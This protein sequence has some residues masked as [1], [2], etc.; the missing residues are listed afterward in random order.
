MPNPTYD[1]Q[2]PDQKELIE[3]VEH[4]IAKATAS[5]QTIGIT[6]ATAYRELVESVR[7]VARKAPSEYLYPLAIDDASGGVTTDAIHTEVTCP[8]NF[9]R[10]L[11][12][13]LGDWKREVTDL[14]PFG[15]D[16]WRLQ[17]NKF[18]QADIYNP[19]A[20]LKPKGADAQV[21]QCFPPDSTDTV[22]EFVFVTDDQAPES[23]PDEL[24]D[25]ISYLAASRMLAN[26]RQYDAAQAL[27]A[28]A[29]ELLGG[30]RFGFLGE[31]LATE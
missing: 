30:V 17:W 27:K 31:D 26:E 25:V 29:G 19:Q 23:V 13:K 14:T 18:S 21:V 1:D 5:D 11:H 15:S 9:L 28:N 2:N 3:L 6:R 8:D 10:F 24:K 20:T 16:A 12:I 4:R 7:Q 22:D